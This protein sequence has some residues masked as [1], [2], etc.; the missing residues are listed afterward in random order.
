MAIVANRTVRTR[1]ID[2]RLH[3][4][5]GTGDASLDGNGDRACAVA[6]V[7]LLVGVLEAELR[8]MPAKNYYRINTSQL[9]KFLQHVCKDFSKQVCKDFYTKNIEE[10]YRTI[11]TGEKDFDADD[12]QTIIPLAA[13]TI[14]SVEVETFSSDDNGKTIVVKRKIPQKVWNKAVRI[15]RKDE[16]KFARVEFEDEPGKMTNLRPSQIKSWNVRPQAKE[17]SKQYTGSTEWGL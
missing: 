5:R 11:N 12:A 7:K 10:E 6:D 17:S 9:E 1:F 4:A 16:D 3:H 15:W 2:C 13:P 8:G 14:K